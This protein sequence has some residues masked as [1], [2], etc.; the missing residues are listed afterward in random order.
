VYGE[1]IFTGYRGFEHN[2]TKPLFPFGFG[3]SYTT[4]QYSNLAIHPV[5]KGTSGPAASFEYEVEFDVTNTGQRSGADVAQ[6]YLSEDH[7]AVDRPLQE[8]K[9]FARVQLN[10]GQARHVAIPLNARS[11]AWYDV[12]AK[13][14]HIDAGNFTVHIARSS[15]DPQLEGFIA[16]AKAALL[17]V[18]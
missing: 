6:L 17:P 9:G 15:A 8:L 2:H 5:A 14:W 4:F 7:P 18:E 13:A 3:L 11:F 10:P 16:I 1:D 12:K